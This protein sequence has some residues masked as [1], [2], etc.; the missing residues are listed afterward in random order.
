MS[1]IDV[2]K[3]ERGIFHCWNMPQC[4]K[5]KK[6]LFWVGSFRL[7]LCASVCLLR[8]ASGIRSYIWHA[9]LA[10]CLRG[11]SSSAPLRQP[12]VQVQAQAQQRM[13]NVDAVLLF[14]A[15][16][17]LVRAAVLLFHATVLLFHGRVLVFHAAVLLFNAA[18]LLFHATVLLFQAAVLLYCAG[19]RRCC[20]AIFAGEAV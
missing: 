3:T 9:P 2:W 12:Q 13:I 8:C 10:G 15:S 1:D 7:L 17:L 19:Q 4:W 20:R 16:V 14:H 18:A 6:L 5:I 11:F